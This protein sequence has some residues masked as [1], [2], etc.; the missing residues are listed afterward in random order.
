MLL[1]ETLDG[2]RMNTTT[3]FKDLAL[4]NILFKILLKNRNIFY[5]FYTTGRWVYI[6]LTDGSKLDSKMSCVKSSNTKYYEKLI[7]IK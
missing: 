1:F 5:V 6:F 3:R 7:I 2:E 4:K